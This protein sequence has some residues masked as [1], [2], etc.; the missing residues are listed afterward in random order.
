MTPSPALNEFFSIEEG[1]SNVLE[2]DV[3]VM[4]GFAWLIFISSCFSPFSTA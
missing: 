4:F 3:T 2:G 1:E